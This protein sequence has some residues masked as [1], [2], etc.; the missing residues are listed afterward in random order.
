MTPVAQN[1]FHPTSPNITQQHYQFEQENK[2][3]DNFEIPSPTNELNRLKPKRLLAQT[4]LVCVLFLL[5]RHLKES[6]MTSAFTSKSILSFWEEPIRDDFSIDL[7]SDVAPPIDVDD[8]NSFGACN[9]VMD[10]NHYLIE[11][12][13]YHYHVMPLRRVILLMDP[14]SRTSPLPILER[15][16]GRI[17]FT[18]W[19]HS[20]IY[21]KGKP[22]WRYNNEM[23]HYLKLQQ[24][25]VAKCLRQMKNENRTWV[26]TTDVDEYIMINQRAHDPQD[27]LHHW[28]RN[29]TNHT[30]TD[31]KEPGYIWAALQNGLKAQND[32]NKDGIC[33]PVSRK[34]FGNI[35]RHETG[36][37]HQAI[38]GVFNTSALQTTNFKEWAPQEGKLGKNMIDVSRVETIK[39][40]KSIHRPQPDYCGA[41]SMWL[42]HPK[43]PF[44]ANHYEGTLKQML[45]RSNDARN[46]NGTAYRIARYNE[47]KKK[48]GA[49]ETE[50]VEGWLEGFI[51]SVG[52]QEAKRL[53]AGVG[54]PYEAAEH[55]WM[56]TASPT[57]PLPTEAP[58]SVPANLT[59]DGT[60]NTT[61]SNETSLVLLNTSSSTDTK[62]EIPRI[63]HFAYVTTG[64][65]NDQPELPP[66]VKENIEL[67]TKFHPEYEVMLWN[68]RAARKH[69]PEIVGN[70]TH[71]KKMPWAADLIRYHALKQFGGIY[72]DTDIVPLQNLDGLRKRLSPMF[73]VCQNPFMDE[74]VKSEEEYV[75]PHSECN[76]AINAIIGAIPRHPVL[77]DIVKRAMSN[78]MSWLQKKPNGDFK[79]FL[80][81]PKT[82][83]ASLKKKEFQEH[84]N[85]VRSPLFLPCHKNC[86][87]EDYKD[88]EHV[89]GMHQWK[90]SWK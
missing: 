21:P 23:N 47:G 51:D 6:M 76:V 24:H 60:A 83:T 57:I 52:I 35:E 81:G 3:T 16:K 26:M 38:R 22:R 30:L 1:T 17:D 41:R 87:L 66:H 90:H 13:A 37:E 19:N 84:S 29:N 58:T 73:G 71:I 53:L 85:I 12:L 59:M 25:F 44:V 64:F 45:F 34:H 86:K 80:T 10:D 36:L 4:L 68:N 48:T 67:W 46:P 27:P 32:V 70:L 40:T 43:N 61:I 63:F 42:P 5:S 55:A 62:T 14:K 77:N 79:L 65:P 39:G 20:T 31:Q 2:M 7:E 50:L 49:N 9:L 11:W 8:P 74:V 89:Y 75:M 15:W 54:D 28:V 82:W 33:I 56:P 69:F 78:S 18:L 72:M 88:S